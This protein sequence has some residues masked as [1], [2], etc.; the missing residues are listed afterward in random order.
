M[1]RIARGPAD[2]VSRNW[3][4][5]LG[6]KL[7]EAVHETRKRLKRLV[8]FASPRALRHGRRDLLGA[9]MRPSAI[10]GSGFRPSRR[11]GPDRDAR[12]AGA[13]ASATS[14]SRSRRCAS[15]SA[16]AEPQ[17]R[18]CRASPR[19]GDGRWSAHRAG[20]GAGQKRVVEIRLRRVR[21]APATQRL[22]RRGRRS[23]RRRPSRATSICTSGESARRTFGM[24]S[25]SFAR[26]P[27]AC[28]RAR[29]AHRLSDVLGDDHDL[30]VLRVQVARTGLLPMR[31][32]RERLSCR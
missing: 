19:P 3:T 24:P 6:R 31:R 12:R 21:R 25:R 5:W 16:R 27:S 30:A 4:G 1:R 26:R 32:P 13:N 28:R 7:D 2:A 8:R 14:C 15:R 10:W 29:R 9:R 18:R 11:E 23:A 17:A 22:Y 20:G